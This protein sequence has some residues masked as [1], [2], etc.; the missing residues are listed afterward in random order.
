[1]LAAIVASA[2]WAGSGYGGVIGTDPTAGLGPMEG[3]LEDKANE[4]AVNRDEGEGFEGS[5]A[6]ADDE[7]N[8]VSFVL[9]GGSAVMSLATFVL[10][11]PAVLQSFGAPAWFADPLGHLAQLLASIGVIQFI[12]NRVYK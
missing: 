1:M 10:D 7:S 2:M 3:D 6:G 12:T 9:N 5:A 11:F 4:S 8:I